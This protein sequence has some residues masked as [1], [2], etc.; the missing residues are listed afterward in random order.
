MMNYVLYTSESSINK[1]QKFIINFL[2]IPLIL[3][4][5]EREE[6]DYVSIVIISILSRV[7]Y[8]YNI[9]LNEAN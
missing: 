4:P 5:E 2:Q 8:S 3:V 6:G 1:A 7:I 9:L